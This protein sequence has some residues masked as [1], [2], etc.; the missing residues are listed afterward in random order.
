MKKDKVK[1]IV[2]SPPVIGIIAGIVAGGFVLFFSFVIVDAP[3]LLEVSIP[4]HVFDLLFNESDG[5]LSTYVPS[6][7]GPLVYPI[8]ILVLEGWYAQLGF[9][10]GVFYWL[11]RKKLD[12]RLAALILIFAL[13]LACLLMYVWNSASGYV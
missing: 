13:A 1:M 3:P 11:L 10:S 5:L 7:R 12:R 2:K 8:I 9:F 6:I 4:I